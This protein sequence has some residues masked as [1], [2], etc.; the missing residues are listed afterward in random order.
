M[1]DIN[2]KTIIILAHIDDDGQNEAEDADLMIKHAKLL[3]LSAILSSRFKNEE[4]SIN[5][6]FLKKNHFKNRKNL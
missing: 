1:L 3:N 4:N 2:K 6:P 5:I